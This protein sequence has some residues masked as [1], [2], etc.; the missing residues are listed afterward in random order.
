VHE[1][2]PDHSPVGIEPEP[3]EHPRRVVVP[4]AGLDA[5]LDQGVSHLL[6]IVGERAERDRRTA[7]ALDGVERGR[8][9]QPHVVASGER[10]PA[11]EA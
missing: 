1:R 3:V 2:Q 5:T 9:E 7:M 6:R 11:A 10:P 8:A 4:R